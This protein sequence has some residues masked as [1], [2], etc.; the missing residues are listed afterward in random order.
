VCP[1]DPPHFLGNSHVCTLKNAGY[2][3]VCYIPGAI[4][5][6]SIKLLNVNEI[7]IIIIILG[8]PQHPH[9]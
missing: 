7:A 4:K 8:E 9:F 5:G 6:A 2:V 1:S 3:L